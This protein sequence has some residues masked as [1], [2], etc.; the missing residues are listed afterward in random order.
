M[1][2]KIID[3]ES[4]ARSASKDNKNIFFKK[5]DQ[6]IKRLIGHKLIT[7]TVIDKS[8]KYVE[9]IYTNNSK[10][11]PLLGTKPVPRNKWSKTIIRDKK[12]FLGK[13]KKDI[14]KLF[15]DHDTIFSLG[16]G[17]IINFIV[18][19]NNMPIG[20]INVL[21]KEY[22]YSQRDIKKLDI[23]SGFM[24]PFFLKHQLIMKK[25]KRVKNAK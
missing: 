4:L 1:K 9:R 8:K 12:N 2:I 15:F 3:F 7:F 22:K 14:K 20:T 11:Y 6:L 17:S 23:I 21:D 16:C 25:N 18:K 19:F 10:V 24:I 13:N 5:V